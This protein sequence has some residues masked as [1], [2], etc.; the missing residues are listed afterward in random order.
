MTDDN[1]EPITKKLDLIIIILL[2]RSGFSQK[3]IAKVLGIS[4]KKIWEIFGST[5]SKIQG[6]RS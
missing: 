6:D 1:I 2:A 3:E 5:F 4:T